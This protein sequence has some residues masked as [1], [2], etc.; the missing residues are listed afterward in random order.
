MATTL[1]LDHLR[2]LV[3]I[4]E[5]G[6]FNKAAVVLHISQPALSQHVRL[7]ER[8]LKRK[9]FVKDGRGMKLT[10]DGEQVL[11]EARAVLAAHDQALE[12]LQVRSERVVVVGSSEHSAEQVLPEMIRALHAAFPEVTTRFE[13]GRST[14]L[15]DSVDKGTVD[16]AFVLASRGNEGGREIGRLPLHWYAAPGWTPPADDAPFPLVAFEE[17]CALRERALTALGSDG[18][19]VA[20]AG[21][22]STLEGVIA[23]V[24]AG[25]GVA[26]LPNV[27]RTPV[28]LVV[29][30]DLPDV[31]SA[32]LNMLTRRGLD[33]EVELTA[34][35]AGEAFFARLSSD[36]L[37]DIAV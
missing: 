7:L 19:R 16:F 13:I 12:R 18:H 37:L 2:T 15:A 8:S 36:H 10:A 35:E 3:A 27:G 34:I 32:G 1:D 23:G 5:C 26:L 4:S 29:R 11:G 6:G 9:L 25:L 31:G 14:Q 20:V 24:R 30:D 22:S 21:Q 17:P 28:G 33:P